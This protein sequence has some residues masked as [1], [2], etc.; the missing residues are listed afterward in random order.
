MTQKTKRLRPRSVTLASGV[1][2]HAALLCAVVL[3]ADAQQPVRAGINV[4]T[5]HGPEGGTV[6]GIIIDPQTPST[7]Y[8]GSDG[9]F[10][11]IRPPDLGK[12]SRAFFADR[13]ILR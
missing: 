3:V 9:L 5:S 13:G 8:A 11:S 12:E 4:W 1:W 10:K 2:R 6:R 7:L